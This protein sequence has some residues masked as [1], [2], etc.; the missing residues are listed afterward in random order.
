MS[1]RRNDLDTVLG[2]MDDLIADVKSVA[3]GLCLGCVRAG[4]VLTEDCKIKEHN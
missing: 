1:F 3:R 4:E 2:D